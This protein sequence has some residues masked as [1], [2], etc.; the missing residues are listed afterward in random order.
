MGTCYWGCYPDSD[1]TNKSNANGYRHGNSYSYI[2]PNTDFDSPGYSDAKVHSAVA[3]SAHSA[4]SHVG[5]SGES[6]RW[7]ATPGRVCYRCPAT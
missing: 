5:A 2:Y 4:T 1:A 6:T 3:A 7:N